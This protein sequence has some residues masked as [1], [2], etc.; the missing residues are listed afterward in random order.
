MFLTKYPSISLSYYSIFKIY[1]VLF[2]LV[3]LVIDFVEA[4]LPFFNVSFCMF[5]RFFLIVSNVF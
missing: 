3:L 4:G 1:D 5:A 2:S